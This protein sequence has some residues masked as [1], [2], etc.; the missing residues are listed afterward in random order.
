MERNSILSKCQEKSKKSTAKKPL[1]RD[2]A[3]CVDLSISTAFLAKNCKKA[4][5]KDGKRW[6]QRARSRLHPQFGTTQTRSSR[7][8]QS[9]P[10][11]FADQNRTKGR[12]APMRN[13]TC[14]ST[15]IR[16]PARELEE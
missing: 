15:A 9:E 11:G 13:A 7:G 10:A 4:W 5:I 6:N 14:D 12:I 8:S 2:D 1:A 3:G 16:K